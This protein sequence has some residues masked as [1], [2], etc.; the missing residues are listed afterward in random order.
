M[1]T[2]SKNKTYFRLEVFKLDPIR[3]TPQSNSIRLVYE[4]RKYI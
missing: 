2:K 1:K 3:W 4:P